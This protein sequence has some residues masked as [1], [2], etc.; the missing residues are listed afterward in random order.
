VLASDFSIAQFRFLQR[1]LL[2]HGRWSYL[3]MATFLRYFFYKNF[4]F[5]LTQFWYA[6]FSGFTMQVRCAAVASTATSEQRL[7]LLLLLLLLPLLLLL[8][9]MCCL[10]PPPLSLLP[11]LLPHSPRPLLPPLGGY[12][13]GDVAP[14][15]HL[16]TVERGVCYQVA[17]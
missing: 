8:Q 2:V 7:L 3:R 5:T 15:D 11:L 1:L 12:G 9:T 14:A 4:A 13:N 16:R 10:L 6:V 17:T